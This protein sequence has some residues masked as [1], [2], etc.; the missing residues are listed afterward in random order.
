MTK[1]RVRR[2]CGP[3]AEGGDTIQFRVWAPRA[4]RVDLVLIDG[5]ARRAVP[6]TAEARGF[7]SRTESGVPEGQ[8]Y[9][10]SRDGGPDRADPCS[11]WQPDN[12]PGPSAV[13][14]PE[15]FSWTDQNW[16]GVAREDLVIYELHVGTF[17]P[18]GTFEA[19][20]PR[21]AGLKDLG[22]TA[23][24]LMPVG[25]FPGGRNWGYDGVL[26]YAA[27]DTYGGPHGLA[28]LVD[29]AHAAGLAV[30][31]DVVYNH[32]G[33]ESNFLGEFGPY[34]T[35]KYKTPWGAAINYD[36]AD[37]DPVRAFALDNA[38]MWLAAFHLDGLRL[39][40]V[41][42]IYDLGAIHLLRE[43]QQVADDVSRAT[44]VGRHVIA[45]SDQND[46]RLTAPP[47]RGGYGL[48]GQWADDLHHAIHA[49]LSGER[50]GYYMEFGA[51]EV[52]A[53]TLR[54]PFLYA[55]E[56]SP[57]RRRRHGAPLPP[58]TRGDG[59]VVCTQNHDQ[60]GNRA[61]GDRPSTFLNDPAKLRF[62]ASVMLLSPYLPMLWMGEEYGETRPFPFFCSFKGE[63]LIRAVRKGR[64]RE[65]ADFLTPGQ[66]VPLP[67]A[68]ETFDS[69][70]LTWSW[71][72]G[73]AH[74]GLRNLYRD[75]LRARRAWPALRD[76]VNRTAD[77][78]DG[79]V[80]Q[81]TRG[82]GGFTAW[83]NLTA[84]PR[85]L[86]RP[87]GPAERVLFASEATRYRGSRKDVAATTNLLPFECVAVGPAS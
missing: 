22:V 40:A 16:A 21:L 54:S 31:L 65:F 67:D 63:D 7:F 18:E 62:A 59:F 38:R 28:K 45:E 70:K 84:Q 30:I 78:L 35:D 71:P 53:R 33:P 36:D 46:P 24:E 48:A 58:G 25:Q 26:P 19:I 5:P 6:M 74:C 4:A 51:P 3:V 69:A 73:T 34:F 23:I 47:E 32:F 9:A 72:E 79:Q 44:G 60:V 42:A 83:F 14:R 82:T 1:D 39:D 10:F 68:P 52:L 2:Q 55:G 17:T 12:V 11:L 81:L 27:Q 64:A 56:Y 49:L 8:R 61:V 20:I 76:F 29:A 43:I 66:H 80:L 87:I 77:V 15:R 75:L 85:P 86:P 41:H 37:S 50:R 13:V 57:L